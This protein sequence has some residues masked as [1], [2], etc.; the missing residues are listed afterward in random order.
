VGRHNRNKATNTD[1]VGDQQVPITD[2]PRRERTQLAR[3]GKGHSPYE[4]F[5]TENVTCGGSNR[6]SF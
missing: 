3:R 5:A 1:S 2:E 4:L 6:W